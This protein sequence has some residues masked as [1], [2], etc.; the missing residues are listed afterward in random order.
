MSLAE[1]P[2]RQARNSAALWIATGRSRGH[3][4]VRRRGFVAVEG[5]ERAGTRILIQEAH[6]DPAEVA[7][8]GEVVRRVDRKSVV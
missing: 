6:L 5:D 8:L 1:A 4:I 2:L 7:E 3:E